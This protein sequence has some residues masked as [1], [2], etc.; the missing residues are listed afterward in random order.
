MGDWT[1][2]LLFRPDVAII[3][4]SDTGGLGYAQKTKLSIGDLK[5]TEAQ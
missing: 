1:S 3:K 2:D 4:R 5:R